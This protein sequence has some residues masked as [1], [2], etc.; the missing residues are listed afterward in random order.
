MENNFNAKQTVTLIDGKFFSMNGVNDIAGF[1]DGFIVLDTVLG[2]ISIEGSDLKVESL[3]S[4]GGDILIKGNISGFF[5]SETPERKK[6]F[7][8][9]MFG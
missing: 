9:K 2:R 5:L 8:R 6:G 7:F 1:D 4:D 3:S